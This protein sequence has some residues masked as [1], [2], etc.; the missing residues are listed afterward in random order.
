[1][2]HD[3]LEAVRL[4]A[5]KG[6]RGPPPR[7]KRGMARTSCDCERD[8]PGRGGTVEPAPV[9]ALR[10]DLPP[11]AGD[12]RASQLR[13]RTLATRA[14]Q[15]DEQARETLIAEHLPLARSL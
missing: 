1:M 14:R 15:G 4:R 9:T 6:F 5:Y 12:R 8:K 3:G 11:K 13:M 10:P 7:P 2:E